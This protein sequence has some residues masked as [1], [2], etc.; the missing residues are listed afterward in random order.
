MK[1]GDKDICRPS[2]KDLFEAAN[3][4]LEVPYRLS[5]KNY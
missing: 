3:I 1:L 5:Q 2:A 4:E